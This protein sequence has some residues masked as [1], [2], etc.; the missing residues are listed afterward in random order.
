MNKYIRLEDLPEDQKEN[1][2]Q[3]LADLVS[4]KL[5]ECRNSINSV[6]LKYGIQIDLI[7]KVVELSQEDVKVL[8]EKM[9]TEENNKEKIEEQ[10]KNPKP[11]KKK[12]KRKTK[13]KT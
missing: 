13:K 7:Y 12:A 8:E 2:T 10:L 1:V 9:K 3:G 11:K 5:I 4:S 6:T